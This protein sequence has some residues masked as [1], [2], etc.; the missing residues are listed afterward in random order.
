MKHIKLFESFVYGRINE[1]VTPEALGETGIEL[2][3]F[4]KDGDGHDSGSKKDSPYIIIDMEGGV[5]FG[6]Y[7]KFGGSDYHTETAEAV[8][9]S[10]EKP[11]I[12]KKIS[13]ANGDPKTQYVYQSKSMSLLNAVDSMNAITNCLY[14][15]IDTN[16][17]SKV[18]SAI[19]LINEKYKDKNAIITKLITQ[20]KTLK[21]YKDEAAAAKAIGQR[22]DGLSSILPGVKKALTPAA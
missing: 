19:N 4:T 22:P 13:P 2:F 8:N 15:T 3:V 20:M 12:Y 21:T 11:R 6:S 14:G 9:N 16:K 1:A 5:T 7:R 17:G 18:M 10:D